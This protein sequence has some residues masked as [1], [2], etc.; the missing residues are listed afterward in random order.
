NGDGLQ[1]DAYLIVGYV[2]GSGNSAVSSATV[3]VNTPAPQP[4]APETKPAPRAE[5]PAQETKPAPR[6][7]TP[8]QETSVTRPQSAASTGSSQSAEDEYKPVASTQS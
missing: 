4:A 6:A 3:A 5:P 2:K 7:E 1:K 8:A